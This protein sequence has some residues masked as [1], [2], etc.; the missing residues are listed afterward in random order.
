MNYLIFFLNYIKHIYFYVN[1]LQVNE[2][3]NV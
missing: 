2:F 1:N 3:V